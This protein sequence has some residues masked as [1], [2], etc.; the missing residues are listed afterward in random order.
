MRK[1]KIDIATR[2]MVWIQGSHQALTLEPSKIQVIASSFLG[3]SW[4]QGESKSSKNNM[5]SEANN[6]QNY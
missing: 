6:C 4:R 3:V 5:H 1:E 2:S